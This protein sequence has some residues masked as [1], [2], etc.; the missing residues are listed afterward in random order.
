MIRIQQISNNITPFAGISF[1]DN[2]FTRSGLGELINDQ[3]NHRV[4]R[5]GYQYSDIFRAWFN[6]F[7]CGGNC[8]EDI[9]Q[10]LRT[11]LK[12]L[13]QNKVPSPDTLLRSLGELATDN[14]SVISTSGQKYQFNINEKLND[15]NVKSLLLRKQLKA[16]KYYDFDYD[17]QII[18]HEKWDA[19]KT[20]KGTNGYFGGTAT[21][22]NMIVYHETSTANVATKR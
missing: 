20:C 13:P 8:A 5:V 17:N 16:G 21:I 7:F 10:H 19:K 6:I 2:E 9:A 1:I 15:L 11:T 14:I 12:N 4:S 22:G 3:L 18:A